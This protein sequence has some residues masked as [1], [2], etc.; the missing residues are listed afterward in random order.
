MFYTIE[1]LPSRLIVRLDTIC[2]RTVLLKTAKHGPRTKAIAYYC[3]LSESNKKTTWQHDAEPYKRHNE[4]ERFRKIF[5]RYNKLGI[6]LF[7]MVF[8]FDAL[9]T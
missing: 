2:L 4:I 7:S 3:C 6:T 9:F 1:S 8:I 5:T